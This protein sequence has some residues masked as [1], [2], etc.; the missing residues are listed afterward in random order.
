MLRK[1]RLV[2]KTKFDAYAIIETLKREE[3]QCEG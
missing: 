1:K 3:Y 2:S